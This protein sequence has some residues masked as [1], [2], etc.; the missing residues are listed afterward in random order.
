MLLVLIAKMYIADC[1]IKTKGSLR[2]LRHICFLIRV[3]HLSDQG[4]EG[5]AVSVLLA[6]IAK[7]Y[8]AD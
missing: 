4:N 5:A 7:M 2:A 3:I 8:L 1:R 6:P